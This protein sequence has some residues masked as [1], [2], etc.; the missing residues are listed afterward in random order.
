MKGPAPSMFIL[1]SARFGH[2]YDFPLYEPFEKDSLSYAPKILH[3]RVIQLSG[4]H[5]TKGDTKPK[6]D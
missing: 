3:K 5:E 2:A 6:L 1:S 4:E